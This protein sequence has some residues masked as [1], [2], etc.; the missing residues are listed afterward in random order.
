M[1]SLNELVADYLWLRH[2]DLNFA[3]WRE[4]NKW[5]V[6]T[7]QAIPRTGFADIKSKG[8]YAVQF[9]RNNFLR[10][11]LDDYNRKVQDDSAAKV[12]HKG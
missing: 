12:E 9:I 10:K 7:H 4:M 8:D 2:Q 1:H 5:L 6:T 11:T 3:M